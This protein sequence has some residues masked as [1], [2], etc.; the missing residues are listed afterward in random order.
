MINLELKARYTNLAKAEKIVNNLQATFLGKDHQKD[1]YFSVRNGQLKL[2]ET[3]MGRDQLIW[4]NRTVSKQARKSEYYLYEVEDTNQMLRLLTQSNGVQTTV[5]KIRNSYLY[6]NVR[7]HLDKVR[8]LGNF[9]EFEAVLSDGR[10]RIM[11]K[12]RIESLTKQFEIKS[13][14]LVSQS[15]SILIKKQK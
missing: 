14:D 11:D 1:T 6:E 9:I 13:R 7:I 15:Y 4:Y 2:R 8:S 10:I 3:Q 5:R 12:E